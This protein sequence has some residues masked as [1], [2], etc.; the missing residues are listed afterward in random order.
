MDPSALPGLIAFG[1][2][3]V[4]GIAFIVAGVIRLARPG[5]ALKARLDGYANLPLFKELELAEARLAIAER[6]LSRAPILQQRAIR[7][8]R[9]LESARDR[10]RGS[11]FNESAVT[12]LLLAVLIGEG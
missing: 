5:L 9:D 2:G 1:V 11:L 7:A 12:G 4:V 6:A 10:V 3:A 8:L